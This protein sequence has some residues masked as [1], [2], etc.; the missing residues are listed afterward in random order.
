ME[1]GG[2]KGGG[3]FW[4]IKVGKADG[5]RGDIDDSVDSGDC[6]GDLVDSGSS[7][8]GDRVVVSGNRADGGDSV[9][10]EVNDRVNCDGK[11][12]SE[13]DDDSSDCDL[14]DGNSEREF[15]K[16]EFLYS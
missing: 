2:G 8:R 14:S 1:N 7:K 5:D 15:F 3:N 9:D 10:R 6:E 16:K 13:G 12:G 4:N 11:D